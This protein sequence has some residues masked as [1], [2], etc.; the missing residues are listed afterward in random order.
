MQIA[1]K[2]GEDADKDDETLVRAREKHGLFC[3]VSGVP[4][5]ALPSSTSTCNAQNELPPSPRCLACYNKFEC[6]STHGITL[7]LSAHDLAPTRVCHVRITA[8]CSWV[9]QWGGSGEGQIG[10]FHS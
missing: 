9:S 10:Y 7:G 4:L 6:R 3:L 8:P 5:G 1:A 2:W